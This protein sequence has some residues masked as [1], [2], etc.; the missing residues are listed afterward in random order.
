MKFLLSWATGQPLISQADTVVITDESE[1]GLENLK[2][3]NEGK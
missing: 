2:F 1:L 3:D